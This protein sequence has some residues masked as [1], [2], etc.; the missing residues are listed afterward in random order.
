M[1]T[2]SQR[3]AIASA[4]WMRPG[5]A[6]RP[7]S[8]PLLPNCSVARRLRASSQLARVSPL[9]VAPSQLPT[10]RRCTWPRQVPPPPPAGCQAPEACS[11]ARVPAPARTASNC[12]ASAGGV[13]GIAAVTSRSWL[14]Q[15]P[16][17]SARSCSSRCV[18]QRRPDS[19]A[20]ASSGSCARPPVS[21][22]QRSAPWSTASGP[23][24]SCCRSTVPS[25]C[26]SGQR[27]CAVR[28]AMTVPLRGAQ[29]ASA[30]CSCS[31]GARPAM[32]PASRSRRRRSPAPLPAGSPLPSIFSVLPAICSVPTRVLGGEAPG[33]CASVN[34]ADSGTPPSTESVRRSVPL[35]AR[36]GT[37]ASGALPARSPGSRRS[38][39]QPPDRRCG[40]WRQAEPA[41][42]GHQGRGS[43]SVSVPALL[44]CQAPP[45]SGVALAWACA[46]VLPLCARSCWISMRLSSARACSVSCTGCGAPSSRPSS[47]VSTVTARAGRVPACAGSGEGRPCSVTFSG[48]DSAIAAARLS[49][50]CGR[51][52]C[53]MVCSVSVCA[54]HWPL[55]LQRPPG[56]CGV[57][58]TASNRVRSTCWRW[59]ELPRSSSARLRSGRRPSFQRPGRALSSCTVA[60]MGAST[61]LLC[62]CALPLRRVCGSVLAKTARSSARVSAPSAASGH[63]AKGS[64]VACR[65][66]LGAGRPSRALPRTVAVACTRSSVPPARSVTAT[67]ASTA[68]PGPASVVAAS[69]PSSAYG[70]VSASCSRPCSRRRSHSSCSA[71]MRCRP[72]TP[73]ATRPCSP[74]SGASVPTRS[75]SMATASMR[76]RSGEA[77]EAGSTAG[78]P[79]GGPA[80]NVTSCAA[81]RLA[82]SPTQAPG[83]GRQCHTRPSARSCV[84]VS[85]ACPPAQRTCSRS[86]SKR[87]D[88][89]A[90]RTPSACTIGSRCSSQRVPASLV[91][92]QALPPTAAASSSTSSTATASSGHSRRS[93]VAIGRGR[94]SSMA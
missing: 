92:S 84:S 46:S 78:W 81:S 17:R 58:S 8:A 39:C 16:R 43:K 93:G 62:T 66:A 35:P 22:F 10:A 88:N 51:T 85:D 30:G 74:R 73:S 68:G 48:P 12:S 76:S 14:R 6:C 27:P 40:P 54:S 70:A 5:S 21:K 59:R 94:V 69:S 89:S 52:S 53:S 56:C 61:A 90:P 36:R 83:T 29:S 34:A 3:S 19:R 64:S 42:P 1:R 38:I 32:R 82:S 80:T 71:S 15:V 7:S 41:S 49:R 86:A 57:P 2:A 9:S 28:L 25:V 44:S 77:S 37:Q 67:S 45:A 13:A 33:F 26:R 47:V 31:S 18:P 55:P 50:R 60:P 24:C 65:S 4:S 72:S 91:S 23:A 87:L 20:S 11:C 63:G 75:V 79:D